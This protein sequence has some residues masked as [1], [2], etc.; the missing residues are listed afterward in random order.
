[1]VRDA[2]RGV[3]YPSDNLKK[4]HMRRHSLWPFALRVLVY[5]SS[6]EITEML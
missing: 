5:L 2:K 1:M 3:D 4:D 6:L